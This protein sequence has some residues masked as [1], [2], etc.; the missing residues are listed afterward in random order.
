MKIG[1]MIYIEDS[2]NIRTPE[3]F[4]DYMT[5]LLQDGEETVN[6]RDVYFGDNPDL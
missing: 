3:E 4:Y 5:E 1:M 2:E 6:I